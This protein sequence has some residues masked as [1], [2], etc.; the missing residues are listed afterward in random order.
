V[1][2]DVDGDGDGDGGIAQL[3]RGSCRYLNMLSFQKLD[4]YQC[5]I[6]FLSFALEI[7]ARLP[8]GH[9]AISEQLRRAAMSVPLNIAEGAG[10][11]SQADGMRHYGISRGLAME[12]AAI[13]D[14]L[15]VLSAVT[16][17]EHQR[18]MELLGRIVAM[19]TKMCQ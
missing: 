17:V 3:G 2:G 1:I 4:V 7:I 5:A 9:A 6:K 15:K 10:R 8:R 13:V 14:S 12:C 11:I 16:E 19:L 18:G